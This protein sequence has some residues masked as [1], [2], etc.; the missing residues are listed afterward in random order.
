MGDST[1]YYPENP[2]DDQLF[3]VEYNSELNTWRLFKRNFIGPSIKAPIMINE[4][5]PY[6]LANGP[7][8][9]N[10]IGLNNPKFL[11][12]M[13]EAINAHARNDK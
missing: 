11:N 1:S 6:Q 2:T 9:P 3:Y 12:F 13:V 8:Q 10:V 4:G 5:H 7:I